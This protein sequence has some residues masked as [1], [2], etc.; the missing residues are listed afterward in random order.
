[1]SGFQKTLRDGFQ[2]TLLSARLVLEAGSWPIS[3]S[4][5]RTFLKFLATVL[6][7]LALVATQYS[8]E[9]HL[10]GAQRPWDPSELLPRANVTCTLISV[11][12]N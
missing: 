9:E 12:A 10:V 2:N 7:Y 3:D 6:S 5:G 11:H 8:R 1:M 4:L